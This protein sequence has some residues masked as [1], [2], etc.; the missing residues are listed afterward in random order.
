MTERG[1]CSA[2]TLSRPSR[3]FLRLQRMRFR[4]RPW[5]LP[6]PPLM[7]TRT[8]HAIKSATSSCTQ[9]L[10]FPTASSIAT[11]RP[12]LIW[13]RIIRNSTQFWVRISYPAI[14]RFGY[15]SFSPLS[16]K[17]GTVLTRSFTVVYVYSL[18]IFAFFIQTSFSSY[19]WLSE[20]LGM[21]ATT[22]VHMGLLEPI[23]DVHRC[24]N[25]PS[26]NV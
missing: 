6:L 2:R 21:Y 23:T 20:E 12:S 24:A 10:T 8:R 22:P 3:R 25:A 17:T 14:G 19:S 4:T 9:A 16:S 11:A 26:G 15:G 18:V 5:P 7:R 13:L 1:R